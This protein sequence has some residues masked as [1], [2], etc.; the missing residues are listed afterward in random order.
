MGKILEHVF[1]SFFLCHSLVVSWFSI[2]WSVRGH[3]RARKC[4]NKQNKREMG[5]RERW[6]GGQ[7][8]SFHISVEM[9]VCYQL[10]S[11]VPLLQGSGSH[12]ESS[13]ERVLNALN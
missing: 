9:F 6:G 7:F 3:S 1:L 8:F 11:V 4:L 5:E 10:V 2:P 12:H 13:P